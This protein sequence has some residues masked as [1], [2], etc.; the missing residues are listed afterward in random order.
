MAPISKTA[1]ELI[2]S[3]LWFK[4]PNGESNSSIPLAPVRDWEKK[5]TGSS[6]LFH[7][8][9][10]GEAERTKPGYRAT[11]QALTPAMIPRT[12]PPKLRGDHGSQEKRSKAG[13]M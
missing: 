6:G 10:E 11:K 5:S 8:G 12:F 4:R 13:A 7:E 2:P 9:I 3:S 1:R